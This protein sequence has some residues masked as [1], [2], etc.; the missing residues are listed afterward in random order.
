M[1]AA[2]EEATVMAEVAFNPTIIPVA[3]T[4][5]AGTLIIS[6]GSTTL[7]SLS[8]MV[9]GPCRMRRTTNSSNGCGGTLVQLRRSQVTMRLV[10][11]SSPTG[12]I[13]G[14]FL[15]IASNFLFL[16]KERER[17]RRKRPLFNDFNRHS[18]SLT[19]YV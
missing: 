2:E 5:T 7:L 13:R 8:S 11:L 10:K 17:E 15:P 9:S 18:D 6:T 3:V 1:V 12:L 4:I 14:A 16:Y 19:G